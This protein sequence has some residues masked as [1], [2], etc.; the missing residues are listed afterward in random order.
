MTQPAENTTPTNLN[1]AN[2]AGQ[3]DFVGIPNEH[4]SPEQRAGEIAYYLQ[5]ARQ[6]CRSDIDRVE[7]EQARRLFGQ[8]VEILGRAIEALYCFQ[9]GDRDAQMRRS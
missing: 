5:E 1:S 3:P 9:G 7:D 2:I 6:E 4:L 8:L